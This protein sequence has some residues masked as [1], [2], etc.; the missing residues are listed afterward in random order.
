MVPLRAIGEALG[1]AVGWDDSTESVTIGADITL[2]IGRD[3]YTYKNRASMSLVIAPII[4]EGRTFVPLAFFRE[5][6]PMNNAY[7]FEGLVVIDNGEKMN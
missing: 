2:S 4:V 1:Y 7:V 6:V 5:V 3:R